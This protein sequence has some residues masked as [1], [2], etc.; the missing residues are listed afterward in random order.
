MKETHKMNAPD[1]NP[2]IASLLDEAAQLATAANEKLGEALA[3]AEHDQRQVGDIGHGKTP[4][5]L[6]VRKYGRNGPDV[7]GADGGPPAKRVA[8]IFAATRQA[9]RRRSLK[10]KTGAG[11]CVCHKALEFDDAIFC[12]SALFA[13]PDL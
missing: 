2:A 6:F 5:S 13:G 4:I 7:K 8:G 9:C 12:L 3:I 11:R 10:S 1:E